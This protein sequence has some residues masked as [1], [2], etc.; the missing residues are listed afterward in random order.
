MKIEFQALH[1]RNRKSMQENTYDILIHRHPQHNPIDHRSEN[2]WKCIVHHCSANFRGRMTMELD[3]YKCLIIKVIVVKFVARIG[4]FWILWK[5]VKNRIRFSVAFY[6][7]R[8]HCK[9]SNAAAKLIWQLHFFC[10]LTRFLLTASGL[11]WS[12]V[13]FTLTVSHSIAYPSLGNANSITAFKLTWAIW[14][15]K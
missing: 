5:I 8:Q 13:S 10:G 1:K 7:F 12:W 9:C 4:L 14:N 6:T 2:H 15:E 3:K 11:V